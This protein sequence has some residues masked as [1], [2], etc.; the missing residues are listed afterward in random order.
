MARYAT[1]GRSKESIKTAGKAFYF[2]TR[3]DYLFENSSKE[4]KRQI[5]VSTGSNLCLTNKKLTIQPGELFSAVQNNVKS[6]NWSGLAQDVRTFFISGSGTA[7]NLVQL[8]EPVF[9]HA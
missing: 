8:L 9:L 1:E 6:E 3:A 5:L 2:I 7:L 4:V